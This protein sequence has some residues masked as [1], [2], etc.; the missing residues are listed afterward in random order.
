MAELVNEFSWS[1]S[2]DRLYQGCQRAYYLNYYASWGGWK[3][4]A[5]EAA[6]KAYLL[7]NMT[8]LPMLAGTVVH[9]VI[10][11]AVGWIQGGRTVDR[12]ALLDEARGRL[13][14]AWQDS[15]NQE[16]KRTSPKRATNLFEHYYGVELGREEIL[17]VRDLVQRCLDHYRQGPL[18]SEILT[19]GGANIRSCEKLTSFD[20]GGVKVW[21]AMDLVLDLPRGDGGETEPAE[22]PTLRIIDWKTGRS[23]E[24][25]RRQ[26]GVYA[27]YAHRE[28]R[29]PAE[30][31]EVQGVYLRSGDVTR[32]RLDDAAL[33]RVEADILDSATR[34]REQLVDP[35]NNI[36][37]E[38]DFPRVEDEGA[39]RRCQFQEICRP[40]WRTTA[41]GG[42]AAE[43]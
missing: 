41:G 1:P 28:L 13:N 37:R 16:W 36:A 43:A 35:E 32:D 18:H 20:L 26:L 6:R 14:R 27:L 33:S 15:R 30:R 22:G 10:E 5:P 21:V 34:L 25:D 19:T 31:I 9:G 12:A 7:K 2:R 8:T 4:S 39:C 17:K 29:L 3:R 40:E 11:R 23:R 24:E 38:E 42:S